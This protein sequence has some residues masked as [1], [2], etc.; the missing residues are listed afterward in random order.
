MLAMLFVLKS[1]TAITEILPT[2][3]LWHFQFPLKAHS[4]VWDN[5]WQLKVLDD[6]KWW[7]MMKNAFYF[8]L[9]APFVLKIFVLTFC[10]CRKND[11]IRKLRLISRFLTSQTGKPIVAI[12]ILSNILRSQTIRQSDNEIWPVNII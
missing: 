9:R 4:E 3:N 7:K 11:L 8:I 6:E 12:Q 1:D 5:F 2:E 10:S